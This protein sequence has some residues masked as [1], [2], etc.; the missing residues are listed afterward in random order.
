MVLREHVALHLEQVLGVAHVV[1]QVR[2]DLRLRLDGAG[3]RLR[4]GLLDRVGVPLVERHRA[5][6]RVDDRL[7]RVL[8]V[9]DLVGGQRRVRRVRAQRV[10]GHRPQ[11]VLLA[12]RV[13]VG[14]GVAVEDPLDPAV[15]HGGVG[16][17]VDGEPRRHLLHARSRLAVVEDLGVLVDPA[18]QHDVRLAELHGVQQLVEQAADRDAVLAVVGVVRR[19]RSRALGEV[20]LD[21]ATARHLADDR[22]VGAVL[23]E[24]DPRLVAAREHVGEVTPWRQVLLGPDRLALVGDRLV[25]AVA[26]VAVGRDHAVAVGV[27]GVP[28]GPV[29]LPVRQPRLVELARRDHDVAGPV[30]HA[31]AVDVQHRRDVVVAPH[32]LQLLE[33]GVGQGRV[34]QPGRLQRGLVLGQLLRVQRLLR[35]ERG[36][37]GLVDA[38]GLAGR[39]DVLREVRRLL[40]RLGRLDLELLHDAG[41]DDPQQDR[42]QHQQRQPDRGQQPGPAEDVGEEQHRAD[43]RDERQDRL[44]GQHGLLVGEPDAGEQPAAVAGQVVAVQPEVGG[45]EQHEAPG[46]HGDLHLRGAGEPVLLR[47]QPDAAEQVVDDGRGQQAQ[48]RHGHAEVDEVVQPRQVEDVEADVLVER[49]V[50]GAERAAVAPEQ[51]LAP[52]AGPGPTGE[53]PEHDGDADQQP[54]A[55]RVDDLAV[56]VQVDLLGARRAG[57]TAGTGRP[58]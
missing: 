4:P 12:V 10:G 16:V 53:Q 26:L 6:V 23:A 7:D 35:R 44:R 14:R 45:L 32:L 50:L 30:A 41:P 37:L 20:Q 21:V 55:K 27:D 49:R 38:V 1:E 15:D 51:E 25:V 57:T 46:Q 29:A 48:H 54:L 2:R 47:L 58:R 5:V 3:E 17:T 13:V 9:V 22:V 33:G 52:L 36:D 42:R 18:R 31:V 11:R 39:R 34:E 24:V 40:V 28:V 56:A 8:H 19:A 43:D